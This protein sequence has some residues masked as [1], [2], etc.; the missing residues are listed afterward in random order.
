MLYIGE[1]DSDASAVSIPIL[2]EA[3]IAEI[4]P[5]STYAG[6]TTALPGV[7][8]GEPMKYDPTGTPTFLRLVPI[9]SIQG[10]ADL[11]ATK[12]AGCQKVAIADDGSLYG[13]GL[14]TLLQLEKSR[15]GVTIAAS[16]TVDPRASTFDSYAATIA[17]TGTDCVFFAG[18]VSAGAVALIESVHAA[19]PTAKIF[20]GDG[21]CTSSFMNP[22]QGGVPRAI[23]SLLQCTAPPP[24]PHGL[25]SQRAFLKAYLARY[26]DAHPDPYAEYGYEAMKLGLDTIAGLRRRGDQRSAVRAALFS[27][28]GRQSVIGSY[29]FQLSGETTLDSY[30]LYKD[31]PGGYPLYQ[32]TITPL[33][34]IGPTSG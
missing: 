32:R 1:L 13:S 24:G 28:Q 3:G 4:S 25:A 26:G 12:Q 22:R 31:G 29:G 20:G 14:A 11:I 8:S 9:D 19:L 10:A 18:R 15:Y 21:I 16:T 23:G 27:T 17:A 2:N 34:T 5:A 30:G 6:L 33:S 7:A